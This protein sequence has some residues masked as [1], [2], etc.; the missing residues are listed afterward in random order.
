M[1]MGLLARPPSH[2][3]NILLEINDNKGLERKKKLK[4]SKYRD[5]KGRLGQEERRRRQAGSFMP[6]T[7]LVTLVFNMTVGKS[8]EHVD[9]AGV[10]DSFGQ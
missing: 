2:F 3:D 7:S 5:D 10:L 8:L 9:S 1:T 4:S 6:G